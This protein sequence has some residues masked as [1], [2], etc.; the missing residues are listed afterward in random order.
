MTA[1]E[2][3]V[4]VELDHPCPGARPGEL[5]AVGPN[6]RVIAYEIDG[7]MAAA[8]YYLGSL[9][10]HDASGWW[11]AGARGERHAVADVAVAALVGSIPD[12]WPVLAE[13][14]PLLGAELLGVA[15]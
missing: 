6:R 5:L 4:A 7:T 8:V 12:G 3:P 1:T 15:R 13:Q 2:I 9:L 14:A 10:R 11:T